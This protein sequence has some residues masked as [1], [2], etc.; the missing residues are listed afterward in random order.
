[1]KLKKHKIQIR[2][3]IT[4]EFVEIEMLGNLIKDDVKE[5]L[6]EHPEATS[7]VE[8]GS[9]SSDKLASSAVTSEKISNSA[10]TTEKINNLAVTAAKIGN[11]AVTADKIGNS[12]VTTDKI[13]DSAVTTAKVNN[14]AITSAK[15]ANGA[16]TEGK[17]SDDLL[18]KTANAYVTPQMYGAKGDGTTNDY[19]AVQAALDACSNTGGT[20]YFPQGTYKVN[21]A[22]LFYSN[23]TLIFENGAVLKQGFNGDNLIR[24]YSE[25]S[26]GEYD[27]VHDVHII[28]ATFD[29][30]TNTTANTLLGMSHAKNIVIENCKFKNAYGS[31][32]DLEIN[33]SYNVKVICCDFEG[34][35]KTGTSGEMIQVDSA[36]DESYYPWPDVKIDNTV[37]KFIDI[38]DCIF[39]DNEVSP[40]IGN[41]TDAA[42]YFVTIHNNIF[43][44]LTSSRGA[45]NFTSTTKEVNIHDNIFNSCTTGVG[46]SVA[47]H[48]IHDNVF[49]GTTTAI[50]GNGVAKNNMINETFTE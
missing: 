39:H 12:A 40:A 27:G 26:W 3:P 18:L 41:H 4:G 7:S 37:S 42:H 1:M 33:S 17:M 15:I 10:V 19:E 22:V 29:G 31:W 46:S 43:T 47:N 25:S 49:I 34:S 30:G 6:D 13:N 2:D 20:V 11:S 45:I 44:G 21:E 23:Q 24:T 16:I 48:Y 32:H 38:H 14:L 35:R 50:V 36:K 9:V 5:W 8:D 28:G